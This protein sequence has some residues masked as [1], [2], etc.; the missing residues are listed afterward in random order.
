MLDN[1]QQKTRPSLLRSLLKPGRTYW[2]VS[3]ILRTSN[4]S[5]VVC[6]IAAERN[7]VGFLPIILASLINCDKNNAWTNYAMH[8]VGLFFQSSAKSARNSSV[9]TRFKSLNAA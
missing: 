2:D 1:K 5:V 4:S 6:W 8:F 7:A 3:R 9:A